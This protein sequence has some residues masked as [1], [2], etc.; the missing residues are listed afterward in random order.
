[1]KRTDM[2]TLA[3]NQT[4]V[5]GPFAALFRVDHGQIQEWLDM[6]LVSPGPLP[7]TAGAAGTN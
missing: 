4:R 7:G 2:L 6:P 1:M 3:N 5:G